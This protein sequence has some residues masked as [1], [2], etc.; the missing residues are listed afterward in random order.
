MFPSTDLHMK[1]SIANAVLLPVQNSDEYVAGKYD[2][3]N[4][5]QAEVK[6]VNH[7]NLV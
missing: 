7:S 5:C 3:P 1:T 6:L 2:V 4:V